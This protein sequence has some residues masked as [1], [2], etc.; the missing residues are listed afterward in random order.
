MHLVRCGLRRVHFLRQLP[1]TVAQLGAAPDLSPQLGGS[2]VLNFSACGAK[3]VSLGP[4]ANAVSAEIERFVG[5]AR[6]AS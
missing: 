1:I 5:P 4:L 3:P 6:E 2:R